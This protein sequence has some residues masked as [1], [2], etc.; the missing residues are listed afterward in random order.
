[1][2]RK[3]TKQNLLPLFDWEKMGHEAHAVWTGFLWSPRL[4]EPLLEVLKS[5]FIA[6]A[7]HYAE[8]GECGRQYA[9][10]LT[11]AGLEGI[12][13]ISRRELAEATSRLPTE[14]LAHTAQ[15]LVQALESAGEQRVQHWRNR[16]LPYLRFI[17]PKSTTAQTRVIESSFARLC[18]AAGDAFPEAVAELKHWLGPDNHPDFIIHIFNQTKLP[19]RFPLVSLDFLDLVT[20]VTSFLAMSQELSECLN[21]IRRALPETV[22]DSRF[23]RLETIVRQRGGA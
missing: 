22:T 17:W 21:A 5:H 11:F 8:L 14:G 6:T 4:Y 10:L 9:A 15:T 2:D 12:N 3:W 20:G 18:V 13:A 16:I 1:V 23:Q 7:T 19:E